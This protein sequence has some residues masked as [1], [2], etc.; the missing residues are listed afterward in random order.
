MN[1]FRSPLN[2]K[3]IVIN[4]LNARVRATLTSAG[5]VDFTEYNNLKLKNFFS[6]TENS[7]SSTLW[8]DS[9]GTY[10]KLNF[11]SLIGDVNRKPPL[12]VVLI[13]CSN[14]GFTKAVYEAIGPN[15]TMYN[16]CTLSYFDPDSTSGSAVS[17]TDVSV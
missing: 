7:S 3:Q 17:T 14:S 5:S 1:L 15:S 4:A 8:D 16:G 11:N 13:N 12:P 6:I 10:A 9:T 2:D